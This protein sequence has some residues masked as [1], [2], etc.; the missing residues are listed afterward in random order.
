MTSL[1]IL[2]PDLSFFSVPTPF[3]FLFPSHLISLRATIANLNHSTCIY[4]PPNFA[5]YLFGL[6]NRLYIFDI[7]SFETT[8]QLRYGGLVD[9]IMCLH[10][11]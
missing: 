5:P 10:A 7:Q 1:G 8:I 11:F 3:S 9:A 6:H 4:L 2:I